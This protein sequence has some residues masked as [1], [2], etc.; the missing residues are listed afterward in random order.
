MGNYW[1][2][3]LPMLQFLM[4]HAGY[5]LYWIALAATLTEVR[6]KIMAY[7]AI[8][9]LSAVLHHDI[10]GARSTVLLH[11]AIALLVGL[12]HL[13]IWLRRGRNEHVMQLI[14]NPIFNTVGTIDM[15]T[16]EKLVIGQIDDLISS[17][18]VSEPALQKIYN[19][20]QDFIDSNALV[21]SR[22]FNEIINWRRSNNVKCRVVTIDGQRRFINVNHRSVDWLK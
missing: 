20:N 17:N 9:G 1:S 6:S 19:N 3:I 13:I 2:L 4:I 14:E 12:I 18:T 15:T 7:V 8:G 16:P 11:T 21:K 5:S 22:I 10:I